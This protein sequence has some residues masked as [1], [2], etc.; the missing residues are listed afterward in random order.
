MTTPRIDP[1]PIAQWSPGLH[2]RASSIVG[3][4]L[5]EANVYGTLANAPQLFEAWLGLGG[6]LLRRSSLDPQDRELAIL[7][8]TAVS[9]GSYPFTQHARIGVDVGLAEDTIEA[10]LI[11][12][13]DRSWASSDRLIL[14]AVDELLI[15]GQL[16][17]GVWAELTTV[18]SIRQVLDL[19]GA[20]AFYRLASWMLNTCRTQ[21]DE[22]QLNRLRP[23]EAQ[24]ATSWRRMEEVRLAAVPLDRWPDELLAETEQ[25]PRFHNRP[26]LRSAGVYATLAN[27][28]D[29][30]ASVGPL[31]AHFLVDNALDAR[32]RELVIVRACLRDQGEYPYRQ[33]VRIGAEA[34][35]DA[36]TMAAVTS[37]DP[38][39]ADPADAAIVALIDEL[40]DTNTVGD[41][42]WAAATSRFSTAQIF[43]AIATAG[44]YGLISFVLSSA[45]T[46][47]EPG[48]T[49][50]PD[51]RRTKAFA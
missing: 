38:Q 47:L 6:H 35:I 1:L 29:L 51:Q 20:V 50:L 16:S 26:E 27:N 17:D 8:A 10:V 49:L 5:R 13:S 37:P 39:L 45:G 22:G 15:N 42:A 21:L 28:P 4:E 43:D 23:V 40:H 24:P 7:R 46:A 11:G 2:E 36:V 18:F 48:E 34:G 9:A 33:H 30:F 41:E 3:G 12:V 14:M 19:I 32:H 31:M 25:W 44:F